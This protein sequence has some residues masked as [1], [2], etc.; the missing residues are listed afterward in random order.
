MEKMNLLIVDD[1]PQNIRALASLIE[2]ADVNIMSCTDGNEALHLLLRN[3]FALAI[4]DVQMP[5]ISGFE[6][7]RL[8]RG[9]QRSKHIPIIFVT[10]TEPDNGIVFEGY[11]KG[12]VDFLLKP[13]NPLIVRSKVRVFI[14]LARQRKE[15]QN[16]KERAEAANLAKS[17]F[18]A[19]M[20]HEIRTPLGVV[21][22]F[23][24]MLGYDD[25]GTEERQR[26]RE[27]ITRN[28]ALL[29]KLIDEILD[30]TKIEADHVEFEKTAFNLR[31]M[32]DELH[33]T[34]GWKA[35]E[36][37]LRFDVRTEGD[38]PHVVD[39]DPLRVR[40]IVS[41]LLSNAIKFTTRGKVELVVAARKAN[42]RETEL[43]FSV[44]DTGIG[45][46]PEA[47]N[48]IFDPFTQ[49]DSSTTR[50]F[51]GTGLG[52]AISLRLARA[53]GGDLVLRRS[54][55]GEGSEF[56]ATVRCLADFG[57][58]S[59]HLEGDRVVELESAAAIGSAE[60]GN[61]RNGDVRNGGE[62]RS[63]AT[64]RRKGEAIGVELD[65]L[66]LLVV[67]DSTD[68]LDIFERLLALHGA[69]V[70]TAAS[71]EEALVLWKGDAFDAVLM[72]I[73]MPGL[74]GFETLGRARESGLKTPVIALTAYALKEERE[75]CL[76]A[77]FS[78]HLRKPVERTLLVSELVRV[79]GATIK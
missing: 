53:L 37:G 77:G 16:L 69:N 32:L 71:G 9:V 55:A 51:G 60:G 44:I 24:E 31:E 20:S 38:I 27:A 62:F 68:N 18:L 50:H 72:D 36:K 54:V 48:R 63:E 76:A 49:A 65:G 45:V 6:L 11:E 67:D 40:Q 21:M 57:R 23:A 7:A 42:A 61:A 35:R 2:A 73:Q 5:V 66:H 29:S 58:G 74:D 56:M 12:A 1:K 59:F 8:M 14:E 22:G 33:Q 3:D 70:I 10:A 15:M 41:N 30:L 75:R 52:L 47:A 17:R 13:I 46:P 79:R 19:N 43:Q 34:M 78:A 39:T 26:Y 25:I 64:P 4:L 28:G